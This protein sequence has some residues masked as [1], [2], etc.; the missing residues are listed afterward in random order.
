MKAVLASV[1]LTII[2]VLGGNSLIQIF[3]KDG[4]SKSSKEFHT[5]VFVVSTLLALYLI[6]IPGI[7]EV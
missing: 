7:W 5:C 4:S 2:T 3:K 6:K 1:L